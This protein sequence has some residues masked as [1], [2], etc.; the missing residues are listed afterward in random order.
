MNKDQRIIDEVNKTLNVM[1][2]IRN[3]DENPFFY[4]RL[5]ARLEGKSGRSVS[6][7]Q[8]FVVVLRP[9]GLA[10]L[11]LVNIFTAVYF[12]N[13]NRLNTQTASAESTTIKSQLTEDF[14]F[15]QSSYI[16]YNE[17]E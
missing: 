5:K 15:S 4:T 13:G 10:A 2:N 17:K 9:V 6:P 16:Y 1:D 7:L 12:L 8:K 11:F 14:R 3:L